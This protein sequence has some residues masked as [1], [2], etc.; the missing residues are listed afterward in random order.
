MAFLDP[1]RPVVTCTQT[2]CEGCPVSST[3]HC[4]F[5]GSDLAYFIISVMPPFLIGMIAVART[6]WLGLGVYTLL[7]LGFFGLLEIRVMCSHCPHYA[8]SGSTLQC[9]A[10]YGMPRLWKYRPGPMTR[11]ETILFFTGFAVLLLVPLAFMLVSSQ[12]LLLALILITG[13]SSAATLLR[14]FCSR[15]FNFACPLNRVPQPIR[16][17]FFA[18]NPDVA[19]AWEHNPS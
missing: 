1:D 7:F 8:E 2:S 18:R 10:N 13:V 11:W 5:S 9:W 14:S 4:H 3:L 6:S 17:E 12:W 15:C 19:R 16:N